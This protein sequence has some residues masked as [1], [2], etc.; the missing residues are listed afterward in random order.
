M[1]T[2]LRTLNYTTRIMHLFMKGSYDDWRKANPR[3]G[4]NQSFLLLVLAIE[5]AP[6]T[7]FM[8]AG[9]RRAFYTIKS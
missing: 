1:F 6:E 4:L 9:M 8:N 2:F 5:K 3:E 7:I